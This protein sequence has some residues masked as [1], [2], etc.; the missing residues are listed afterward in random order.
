M[1]CLSRLFYPRD[2]FVPR[3]FCL[4]GLLIPRTFR[5]FCPTYILSLN[6]SSPDVLSPDILS[7]YLTRATSQVTYGQTECVRSNETFTFTS[8]HNAARFLQ[9]VHSQVFRKRNDSYPSTLLIPYCK[10]YLSC[11]FIFLASLHGCITLYNSINSNVSHLMNV[12]DMCAMYFVF[13]NI[14]PYHIWTKQ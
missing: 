13:H 14:L 12:R 1:F 2:I 4:R 8:K 3:T 5:M 10:A 9:L 7:A 6:V 11:M